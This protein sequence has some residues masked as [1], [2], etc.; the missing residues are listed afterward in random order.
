[1]VLFGVI[2]GYTYLYRLFLKFDFLVLGLE[3]LLFRIVVVIFI[4]KK[5]K[6]NICFNVFV[7]V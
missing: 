2:L 5:I 6:L 1:M 3:V 7:F 4:K